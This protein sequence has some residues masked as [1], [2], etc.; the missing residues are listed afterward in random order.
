MKISRPLTDYKRQVLIEFCYEQYQI[1]NSKILELTELLHE[2]KLTDEETQRI[3]NELEELIQRVR[4]VHADV[5]KY[6]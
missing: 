4:K 1:L 5:K 6:C 3:S 2:N